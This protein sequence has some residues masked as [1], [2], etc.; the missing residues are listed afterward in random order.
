MA[1]ALNKGEVHLD[2]TSHK[3][4]W[5]LERNDKVIRI[6]HSINE[7]EDFLEYLLEKRFKSGPD[8]WRNIDLNVRRRMNVVRQRERFR[9][10]GVP[11]MFPSRINR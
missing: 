10:K 2:T 5:R 1:K 6:F 3:M 8:G 9:T 11:M 4:H 7:M